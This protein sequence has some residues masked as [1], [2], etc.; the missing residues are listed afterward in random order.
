M[1]V[2]A[3][4]TISFQN[5]L[6]GKSKDKKISREF[7]LILESLW[8]K[9]TRSIVSWILTLRMNLKPSSWKLL[10][11]SPWVTSLSIRLS[12]KLIARCRYQLSIWFMHFQVFLSLQRIWAEKTLAIS[13]VQ[14]KSKREMQI[15][16]R[17]QFQTEQLVLQLIHWLKKLIK[18]II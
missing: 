18:N 10:T 14:Q 6:C 16:L 17:I 8:S 15:L 12:D 5:L 2:C 1:T 9:R 7:W 11:N 13:L 3:T 4:L